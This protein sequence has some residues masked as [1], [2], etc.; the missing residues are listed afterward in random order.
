MTINFMSNIHHAIF[1]PIRSWAEH[2]NGNWNL[3][4]G[5]GFVLLVVGAILT[6]VFHRK[7]GPSDERTMGISLKTAYIMLCVFIL[8]DIIFPKEYM[9]QI[10]LL[11]KYSFVFFA[12]A[13][14]LAIRYKKEFF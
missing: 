5:S 8:C 1:Q 6:Y 14:Y 11:F 3:L 7:M 12:A 2:S 4:V 9:W 10:F 13:I